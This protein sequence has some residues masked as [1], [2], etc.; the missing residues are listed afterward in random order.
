MTVS[1]VNFEYPFYRTHYI[2]L[3]ISNIGSEIMKMAPANYSVSRMSP[4]S[5]MVL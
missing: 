2:K 1:V 4:Y 3:N 5:I